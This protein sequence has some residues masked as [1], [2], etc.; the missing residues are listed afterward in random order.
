[1]TQRL[2]KR[3]ILRLGV[4]LILFSSPV[5]AQVSKEKTPSNQQSLVNAA[6][7]G[8]KRGG[9]VSKEELLGSAKLSLISPYDTLF[10]IAS[11]RITR[12]RNGESPAEITNEN[13]GEFT[14]PVKN[15]IINSVKGDKLYF[16]YIKCKKRDGTKLSVGALSFIL[17]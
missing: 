12:I 6:Q 15:L 5:V 9:S 14:E 10:E 16:E 3:N 17:E 7:I 13:S 11:F 4:I 2:C 1:M 8:L